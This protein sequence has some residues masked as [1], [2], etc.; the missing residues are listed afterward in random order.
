LSL[1]GAAGVDQIVELYT[2]AASRN[3]VL[4]VYSGGQDQGERQSVERRASSVDFLVIV[5]PVSSFSI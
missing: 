3:V 4:G 1:Y 2:A 5:P